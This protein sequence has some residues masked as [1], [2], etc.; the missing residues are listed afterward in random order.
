MQTYLRDGET[1]DPE[2][3]FIGGVGSLYRFKTYSGDWEDNE[4]QGEGSSTTHITHLCDF[5]QQ[6]SAL[7]SV[8]MS[9]IHID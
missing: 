4:K 8:A 1:G 9:S 7:R 3:L 2:R 5:I 6:Y